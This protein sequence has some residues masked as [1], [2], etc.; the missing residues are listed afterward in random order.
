VTSLPQRDSE[1][2]AK[3]ARLLQIIAL[4]DADVRMVEFWCAAFEPER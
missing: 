3:L 2:G 4:S 1:F